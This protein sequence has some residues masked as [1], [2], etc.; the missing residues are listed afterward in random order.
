MLSRQ[1]LTS[2]SRQDK[3]AG[4]SGDLVKH[5]VY[6]AMPDELVRSGRKAHVVEA[7]GGKGEYV[8]STH[9][10][11]RRSKQLN[12]PRRRLDEPK[13]SASP[14]HPRVSGSFPIWR[15][16]RSLMRTAGPA[17]SVPRNVEAAPRPRWSVTNPPAEPG[18]LSSRAPQRGL[19]ATRERADPTC[20]SLLG[21]AALT[22]S[23][24]PSPTSVHEAHIGEEPTAGNVKQWLPPRQSRGA[25]L[26]ARELDGRATT[27]TQ[28]FG[29]QVGV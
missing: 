15:T 16:P 12:T 2:R 17:Q 19:T 22:R 29:Q 13:R 24:R 21:F 4:N 14:R 26:R 10:C 1:D 6:L 5:T 9:T 11:E 18:A 7:H 8:S 20:R 28:L 27:E 3:N 25:S 23:G